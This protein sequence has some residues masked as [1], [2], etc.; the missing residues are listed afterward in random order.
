MVEYETGGWS[1]HAHT[2]AKMPR[3]K[4]NMNKKEGERERKKKQRHIFSTRARILWKLERNDDDNMY[5]GAVG[6]EQYHT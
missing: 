6:R 4:S 2:E 3:L 5:V 1:A